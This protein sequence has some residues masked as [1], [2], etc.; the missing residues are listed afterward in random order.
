MSKLSY[1]DCLQL[2][3]AGFPQVR[4]FDPKDYLPEPLEDG[5]YDLDDFIAIP[6]LSELIDGC[7][8]GLHVI[9]RSNGLDGKVRWICNNGLGDTPEKAVKELYIQLHGKDR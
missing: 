4:H 7:G 8:D 1:K 3:E 2:K 6:T 9:A 5:S